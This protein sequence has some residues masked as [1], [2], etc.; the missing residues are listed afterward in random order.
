MAQLAN[1]ATGQMVKVTTASVAG[2]SH[3]LTLVKL[4]SSGGGGGGG[5]GGEPGDP[6]EPYSRR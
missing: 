5:G 6:Y 4:S 2:H 3:V 1:V